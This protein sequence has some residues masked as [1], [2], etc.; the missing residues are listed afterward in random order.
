MSDDPTGSATPADFWDEMYRSGQFPPDATPSELLTAW[1]DALPVGR[2][3]DVGAGVGLNT[4]VLVDAGF[5]VDAIDV[6]TE[7]LSRARER[8][9]DDSVTWIEG[10]VS[11]PEQPPSQEYDVILMSQFPDLGILRTLKD[12][13]ADGGYLLYEHHLQTTDPVTRGPTDDEVPHADA[14]RV[15][16]N[17]LLRA[18]LDLTV[19]H[20]RERTREHGD[21]DRAAIAELVARDTHGGKQ[22]YPA[23]E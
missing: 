11:T 14:H 22:S 8:V 6:S 10:D 9:D 18:G 1:I 4:S 7:A 17:E 20:Y 16:S 23:V 5:A 21:G 3:L 2:A 15:R 19:I 12:A 13:L